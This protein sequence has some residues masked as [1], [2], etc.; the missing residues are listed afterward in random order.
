MMV[1]AYYGIFPDSRF[2]KYEPGWFK[3]PCK[4]VNF[5]SGIE[6]LRDRVQKGQNNISFYPPV[7]TTSKLHPDFDE[8][9]KLD[10][11]Y[12]DFIDK[13]ER[14]VLVSFGVMFVPSEDQMNLLIEAMQ[15]SD[16]KKIGYI[17]SLKE[18]ASSYGK[19]KDL[20]LPNVL[21]K[22]RVPQKQLMNHEKTTLFIGHCGANGVFEALYYGK[23]ILGFPQMFE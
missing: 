13:F 18:Y 15:L 11:E 12:N 4:T 21:L 14:I 2:P 17:I 23:P 20:N 16:P 3:K 19:V 9:M 1:Y 5:G 7:P 6:G 8:W 10:A 22:S